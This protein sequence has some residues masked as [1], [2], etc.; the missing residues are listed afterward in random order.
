M[1]DFEYRIIDNRYAEITEYNGSSTSIVI[2][3]ELGG[4]PVT[5]LGDR[6]LRNNNLKELDLKNVTHIRRLACYY[7]NLTELDLKN[8]KHIEWWAFDSDVELHQ[9]GKEVQI[10]NGTAMIVNSI[11][12]KGEFNIYGCEYFNT[13]N[14]CFVAQPRDHLVH[15]D[16]AE[17]AIKYLKNR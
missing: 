17:E 13:G 4:Y 2:P 5:H 10:I 15:G 6:A 1:K 9:N 7:N 12:K 3:E 8:V 14:K 16:T 11:R